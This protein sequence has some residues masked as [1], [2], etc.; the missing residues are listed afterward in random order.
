MALFDE[1][2]NTYDDFCLT[3]IGTFV[4]RIERDMMAAIARPVR[5][6]KAIDLGCGTGTY[7]YWLR[8]MGLSV[9]GVDLS[10]DMLEV[11]RG[12]RKNEVT[13]QK[14]D[15]AHL[16]FGDNTFD[17]AICNV[18]LEFID[19]PATVLRE[20]FRV[21]KPGGR[22]IV[23]CINKYGAWGKKYTRRGQEDPMSI[24]SHA[25][26]LS[27]EDIL[28]IGPN[29]PTDVRF[30]LFVE[31]EE[32]RDFEIAIQLEQTHRQRQDNIGGYFVIR[33]EK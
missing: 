17:L 4:D 9:V 15:L 10:Q 25:Q 5:G 22:L 6:E 24:Y 2:A 18:V 7:A 32:F 27:Y 3:P 13:F 19:E 14:A 23:G 20:G 28:K 31:P 12:K 30:G 16:P 1:K 8:D 21:L 29:K 33:F 26:F 11:A